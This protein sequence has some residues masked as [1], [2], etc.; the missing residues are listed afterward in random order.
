MALTKIIPIERRAEAAVIAWIRH[1]K[2]YD[3]MKIPRFKGQRRE[4][5]RLLAQRSKKLLGACRR[6]ELVTAAYPLA[7]ALSQETPR[8]A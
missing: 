3:S 6:G 2:G 5:H 1:N 4:V 7:G 8:F